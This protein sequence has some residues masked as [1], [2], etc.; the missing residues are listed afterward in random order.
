MWSRRRRGTGRRLSPS[1]G[2]AVPAPAVSSISPDIGDPAG[3]GLVR[4]LTGT[5]FTGTTGVTFGG[6]AA[7]SVI[8]VNDTTITCLAPAHAAGLVD[9]VVTNPSGSD[10]LTNGYEYFDPGSL[11]TNTCRLKAYTG[12]TESGGAVSQW[13]DQSGTGNHFTQ[14]TEA[15]KPTYTASSLNGRPGIH[16]DGIDDVLASGAATSAFIAAG[17]GTIFLVGS[18]S[19]YATNSGTLFNNDALLS[20]NG[21]FL[22]LHCKQTETFIV[23]NWDGSQDSANVTNVDAATP[24]VFTWRHNSAGDG[25][26]GR[27]NLGTATTAASGNT[28]SLASVLRLG[29]SWAT[30]S[31]FTECKLY[32]V[33]A[34]STALSDANVTKCARYFMAEWGIA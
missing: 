20:N 4:T 3:G 12:V 15:A 17:T 7:T 14:A 24:Y 22:G 10:T 28:T 8:V 19:V 30:A 13:S 34:F 32:E 5:G 31:V 27:V 21:G 18:I 2:V 33:A 1:V 23:S 11:A 16:F 6:D 25:L 26:Y 9:V 29:S